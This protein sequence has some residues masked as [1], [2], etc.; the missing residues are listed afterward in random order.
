MTIYDVTVSREGR[1]WMVSIPAINGLTQ[2]RSVREARAMAREYIAVTLDVPAESFDID[3]TAT[4]VGDIDHVTE[5]LAD[6][7]A[8]R[9]RGEEIERAANERARALARQLAA[10][11]ITLRDIGALMDVSYQRAHQLVS[12]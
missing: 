9:M 5:L 12:S 7:R 4:K 1:W 8:E 11:N 6:I 10:Q 3:V 2:A